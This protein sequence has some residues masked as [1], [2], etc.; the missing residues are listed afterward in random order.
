MNWNFVSSAKTS[1]PNAMRKS[2]GR[3]PTQLLRKASLASDLR[4][5][6]DSSTLV[7]SLE[8][9]NL[10]APGSASAAP[11][12]EPWQDGLRDVSKLQIYGQ[13]TATADGNHILRWCRYRPEEHVAQGRCR[14]VA[15]RV[16]SADH[17]A[18]LMLRC[19][20]VE[21]I[22]MPPTVRDGSAAVVELFDKGQFSTLRE[23]P[24]PTPW[25]SPRDYE[26]ELRSVGPQITVAVDGTVLGE[27][28]DSTVPKRPFAIGSKHRAVVKRFEYLTLDSSANSA[29]VA[30]TPSPQSVNGT[31]SKA[32]KDAPSTEPWQDLLA[33][34]KSFHF[35]GGAEQTA[36][37]LIFQSGL[38]LSSSG[39]SGRRGALAS[40]LSG[41]V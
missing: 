20:I 39:W 35:T 8:V 7:K 34:P 29:A 16:R 25:T 38:G 12:S 37:G 15:R 3:S 18:Q 19:A 4:T 32:T 22:V 9:L 27:V 14:P 36:T 21:T 40:R 28:N 6:T 10:D 26:L 13:A 30:Q 23:F 2:L 31:A 41:C 11:A 1:R 24:L 5:R 17:S 33:S